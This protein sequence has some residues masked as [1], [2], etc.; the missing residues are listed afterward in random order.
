MMGKTPDVF[1]LDLLGM[2]QWVCQQQENSVTIE[3]PSPSE[4]YESRRPNNVPVQRKLSLPL[5]MV[6]RKES[7]IGL[8]WTVIGFQDLPLVKL[9][10]L[11]FILQPLRPFCRTAVRRL[12]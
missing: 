10:V 9:W 5:S 3:S 12:K 2:W 7:T 1:A 8:T 6:L 4:P 11:G